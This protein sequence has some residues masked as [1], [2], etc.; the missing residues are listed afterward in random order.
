M[1]SAA[2][3]LPIKQASHASSQ[4]QSPMYPVAEESEFSSRD[5][6]PIEANILP[7][8]PTLPRTRDTS[9]GEYVFV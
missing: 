8:P 9:R 7:K 5:P 2:S 3:T 4:L 1:D 6:T